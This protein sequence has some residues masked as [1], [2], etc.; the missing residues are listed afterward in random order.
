VAAFVI[1]TTKD[2]TMDLHFTGRTAG[3]LAVAALLVAGCGG[4]SGGSGS[5]SPQ[6]NSASS[7]GSGG[8]GSGSTTAAGSA[9]F[10]VAV[11]EKWV[12]ADHL[13][14]LGTS[15]TTNTIKAVKPTSGGS[16]VTM[17]DASHILGAPAKPTQVTYMFYSD[18]SIGVPFTQVNGGTVTIRSGSIVW[19]PASA[20]ASGRCSRR[21]STRPPSAAARRS[22]RY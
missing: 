17:T 12:Y 8:T 1:S 20:I 10:P 15:T 14:G 3:A 2:K 4:G 6:A 19:P 21:S 7:S 5:G 22:V 11:G 16:M 9:L 18:G 13:G